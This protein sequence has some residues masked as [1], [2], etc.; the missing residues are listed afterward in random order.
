ME[1]QH[2]DAPESTPNKPKR[3]ISWLRKMGR[4][5]GYTSGLSVRMR[6]SCA[7][8]GFSVKQV[9]AWQRAHSV[10]HA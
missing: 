7:L 9:H 2:S 5:S 6:K 8:L 3:G 1:T 4:A 10:T